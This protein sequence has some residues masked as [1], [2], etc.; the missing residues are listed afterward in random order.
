MEIVKVADGVGEE[1]ASFDRG[2]SRWKFQTE[3][4]GLAIPVEDLLS[5]APYWIAPEWSTGLESGFGYDSSTLGCFVSSVV[6]GSPACKAGLSVGD[7]IMRANGNQ[8]LST[9]DL[10]VWMLHEAPLTIAVLREGVEL[11][12]SFDRKPWSA[13]I[14]SELV[15]GLMWREVEGVRARLDQFPSSGLTSHGVVGGVRLSSVHKGADG[16]TLELSGWLDVPAAGHWSFELASDDGSQFY[17]RDKLLI[18]NDGLH[19]KMGKRAELD[20]EAG[21]HPIRIVYFEAGGDEALEAKWASGGEELRLIPDEAFS[22][23]KGR[24]WYACSERETPGRPDCSGLA[25]SLLLR[26]AA[27]LLSIAS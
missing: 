15:G 3:A 18:D 21:L 11:E 16:F 25:L 14:A 5:F 27:R 22:H 26:E 12:V 4:F 7:Q 17:L 6:L 8:V 1:G 2:L 19:A 13:P 20:L 23:R 10:C 9:V 24:G